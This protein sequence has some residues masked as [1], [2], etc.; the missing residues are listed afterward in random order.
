M[1]KSLLSQK[2]IIA[3]EY[4]H[5]VSVNPSQLKEN[6]DWKEREYLNEK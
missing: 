1:S 5:S 2:M 6:F 3:S 4:T